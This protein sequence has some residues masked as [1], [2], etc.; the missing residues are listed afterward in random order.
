MKKIVFTLS[1]VV[2]LLVALTA[3][4][5]AQETDGSG[6][7]AAYMMILEDLWETDQALNGEKYLAVDL[8]KVML[9]DTEALEALLQ[10]FCDAHGFE[11][12][13]DTFDGLVEKDYIPEGV[14]FTEGSFI[15]YEDTESGPDQL[16]TAAYKWKG[17]LGAIGGEYTVEK[18]DGAWE[19][20]KIEVQWIS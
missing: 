10:E 16:V 12:L 20:T 2:C 11:L 13:L 4:Q 14:S 3:C 18:K 19:I 8:S 7:E 6:V 9:E 5:T 15:A 17:N 1:L